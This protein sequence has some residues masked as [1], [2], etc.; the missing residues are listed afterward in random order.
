[1]KCEADAPEEVSSLQQYA[2]LGFCKKTMF[3]QAGKVAGA[4]MT[5]GHPQNDLDIAQPARA[6]LDIRFELVG[7]IVILVVPRFLLFEFGLKKSARRPD[8]PVVLSP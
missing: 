3:D 8:S 5:I 6:A 1:M 4:E 7:R 2:Q